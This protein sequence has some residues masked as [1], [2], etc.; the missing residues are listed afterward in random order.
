MRST[1]ALFLWLPLAAAQGEESPMRWRFAGMAGAEEPGRQ[2]IRDRITGWWK[3]FGTKTGDLL[4]FFSQKNRWDVP[5]WMRRHLQ[6]IHPALMWEYGPAVKAKG[7]RL[8]ITVESKSHLRP[9]A[10]EILKAAPRL[11]GWEFYGYRLP[12]SYEAAMDTV[13]A[14]TKG[15]I[16]Q[17]EFSAEP[18]AFH[19]IDCVFASPRY[20][21]DEQ[22]DKAFGDVFVAVECLVGEENLNRWI[23]ALQVIPW[24]QRKGKL[25]PIREFRTV[26]DRQIA[27][28]TASL[29]K[30]PVHQLQEEGNWALYK[31]EPEKKADYAA[32]EDMFVGKSMNERLWQ[33]AHRKAPFDSVRYSKAGETFCYVKLDGREAAKELFKDKAAIEDALEEALRGADVGCFIG[34]GTGLVYSY[35]DLS[36]ADLNKAV[37]IIRRVLQKGKV[38]KRSWILF[39]DTDL[40]WEWIGIWDD[41]PPPPRDRKEK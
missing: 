3:E 27:A 41:S 38:N 14:R 31:L 8:V 10:E 36:V 26:V 25:S 20:E 24:K 4:D 21:T 39:Y 9:L 2:A 35:V 13:K 28:V 33:N 22:C 34:G 12:E 7:H 15:D 18:G 30:K 6:A 11:E 37:P 19:R 23:G 40:E 17:T 16:T 1:L 29:P 32:Q 5:G